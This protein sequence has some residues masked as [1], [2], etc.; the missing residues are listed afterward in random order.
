MDIVHKRLEES[1]VATVRRTVEQRAGIKDV[2]DEL[3]Q[4][5]PGKTIAGAPFCIFQFVTSVKE[6]YDVEI[7]FPVTQKVETGIL[8]SR[9]LPE[10]D[11]LS[12][13]HRD[14]PEEL[15]ET[16]GTLYGYAREHGI[17]SDEFCR[18]VYPFDAAQG[19]LDT[20]V[21]VQFV[22]HRWNDRLA[23]N[24][25]RV[26]GEETK[27]VVMQGSDELGIE[28]SVDDRFRWVKGMV[29]RLNGLADGHQK[30]DIL[31]S[32]AHVFPA[33][34]IAKL[35][36]VYEETKARTKDAMQAVDAVLN[37]MESDP[38]WGEERPLREGH[39]IYSAKNPRD[40]KG[41]EN[42]QDD[43]ERRRAYCFCP[44][45]RNHMGQG[46]PIAFCY[47]GSG[48]YRQQWE[49]AIGRSVTVEI[50][51]SVLKGDKVCQFAIQLPEDL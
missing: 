43:L 1:L 24:L 48:W 23:E 20:G 19:R 47:C 21:E 3:A 25:D 41:Y 18:E 29:E 26:L 44:L 33:G 6:G 5:V 36:A 2:L 50:V 30:Y 4:E 15:G 49:G 42:A 27:Q 51:K 40:P 45:V 46:M 39:V 28:S 11:V 9:V 14:S 17:I 31:S 12:I 16:Y 37:F 7:G 34:Q 22:I 35:K 13:V 10:M 8:K 32:C 38:G